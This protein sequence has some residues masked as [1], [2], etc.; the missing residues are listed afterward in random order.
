[1]EFECEI[2]LVTDAPTLRCEMEED[3]FALSCSMSTSVGDTNLD[4]IDGGDAGD[5]SQYTGLI[6]DGN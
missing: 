6:I 5:D 4:E 1:M 3:E 2:E